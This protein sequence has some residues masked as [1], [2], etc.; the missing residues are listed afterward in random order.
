MR[1]ESVLG[2]SPAGFHRLAYTEWGDPSA[3]VL[4]C[5]HGMARNGRDFDALAGALSDRRR[6]V[7]PDVVG[8]GG[9]D[10][11]PSA[12]LYGF[13][14]YCADMAVLIARLGVEQV[15]WVGTSMGG[16]IGMILAAQPK[17]PI[18]RLVMNDVGAFVPQ[19]A[20]ERIAD[21]VG[22]DPSFTDIDQLEAY[23]RQIY[24]PFGLLTPDQ[25]KHL[26]AHSARPKPDGSLGL[27]YDP[28]IGEAFRAQ[29]LVDY[30]FWAI[31]ERITCPV[32][33]IRGEM[34]DV[35]LRDTADQMTE[36]GPAELVQIADVGHAPPLMDEAQI[37]L[38]RDW[39][40][41]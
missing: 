2:L 23:L 7:C 29:G 9:S 20:V 28:A 18:A 14:Q 4:I 41:R 25:W 1:Q 16:L 10:W 30:D 31:Y 11:L 21:Y 33:V 13:P 26:A 27:A 3:P 5:A 15:D 37:A 8:R 32:L 17:S 24:A 6:V 40:D 12:P 35:L 39:L 19:A 38:V 36:R 22:K 34:S